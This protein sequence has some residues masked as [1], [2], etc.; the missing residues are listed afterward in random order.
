MNFNE[1]FNY[2]VE[3]TPRRTF[4]VCALVAA[5]FTLAAAV[6]DASAMVDAPVKAWLRRA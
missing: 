3:M 4:I 2:T 5:F 6:Y 1:L